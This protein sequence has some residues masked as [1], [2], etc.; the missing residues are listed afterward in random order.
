MSRISKSFFFKKCISDPRQMNVPTITYS[1]R[2][3]SPLRTFIKTK[4]HTPLL[5][6]LPP[7]SFQVQFPLT[8]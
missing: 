8:S 5:V 1:L 3:P 7:S 6:S 4:V 2:L